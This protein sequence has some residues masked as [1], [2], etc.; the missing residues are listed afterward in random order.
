MA[1]ARG[2]AQSEGRG[3]G[4]TT[5]GHFRIV[6]RLMKQLFPVVLENGWD[7]GT[8]PGVHVPSGRD[9]HRVPDLLV[10]RHDVAEV[11]GNLAGSGVLLVAAIVPAPLDRHEHL[12]VR[13]KAYATA[14]VPLCLVADCA[15]S[16][17][18]VT[19]FSHPVPVKERDAEERFGYAR[20]TVV[21]AGEPLGLPE[22]FDLTLDTGALFR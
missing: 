13:P 16:L 14:G 6:N 21:S 8:G 19:L 5:A 3:A 1:M 2:R 11:D 9:D 7:F 12:A 10:A 22:P 15:G 18:V 4:R 20:M 17:P